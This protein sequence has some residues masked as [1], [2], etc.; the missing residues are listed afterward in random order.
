VTVFIA[1]LRGINV[2]GRNKLPMAD[3]RALVTDI[4]GTHVQT[5]IQSGNVVFTSRK[6]ASVMSKALESGIEHALGNRVPVLVRTKEELG[7]L[8]QKN[9]YRR[10]GDPKALHVT[11]MDAAP[12]ADAVV[13]LAERG[14]DGD[15]FQVVGRE[16]FLHCPN[17]YGNTKLTNA[18]FEKK[19]GSSATTRNWKT[20]MT[21]LEMAGT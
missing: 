13:S 11:F 4:G 19:F 6:S 21:L 1:M 3:L 12:D 9:P 5:Y 20:V 2:S 17:G 18:L 14:A 7:A 15:E 8:V 16:V 10:G